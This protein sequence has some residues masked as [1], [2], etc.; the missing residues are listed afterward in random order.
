LTEYVPK[1]TNADIALVLIWDDYSNIFPPHLGV[2]PTGVRTFK[3]KFPEPFHQFAP[4]DW[5]QY[6]HR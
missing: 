3:S 4:R 2:A 5:S 6:G 1:E